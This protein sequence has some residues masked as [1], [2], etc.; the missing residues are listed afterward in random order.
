VVAAIGFVGF[1]V[2]Q[3]GHLEDIRT[4]INA[5]SQSQDGQIHESEKSNA[6][7]PL[8][9]E[10]VYGT[11]VGYDTKANIP[12][13]PDGQGMGIKF[14]ATT[15]SA[16]KSVRFVQR[17][18]PGYSRG[19]GGT[20]T[21]TV[22]AEDS[23]GYPSG[24]SLGSGSITP[25][26]PAEN[27]EK[28]DPVN[29]DNPASLK[30][31][32]NY[33]LEFTNPDPANNISVNNVLTYNATKPRQPMFSDADFGVKISKTGT[34]GAGLAPGYTPVVDLAYANGIHDGQSYYEAMIA[35]YATISG[36]DKAMA[37]EHFTVSGGDRIVT[38]SSVRVRRSGGTSPLTM[39]LE[40]GSGEA[41]EA[42]SVPAESVPVSVPGGDDGGAVWATANFDS[43]HVLTDGVTYNVRVST[44][45]DTTYTT[46]PVRSGDD[47]GLGSYNF[48][49]GT[50]QTTSNGSKWTE[51]YTDGPLR[52]ADMQF[53]LNLAGKPK[54]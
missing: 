29:L 42:V 31:G 35:N 4:I 20:T 40:T 49:G 48:K 14:K 38:S 37:R 2:A 28:Y 36:K 5:G 3:Q 39:T 27:W 33:Y 17:G 53:Y 16:L 34:W 18:G 45:A 7:T 10:G 13:G 15:S 8:A 12:V 32:K 41:I 44:A 46:H 6:T 23:A 22:R 50:G 9:A 11:G 26:N 51:M 47:K 30:A 24:T 21:L 19:N 52:P 54:N 43:P 25:G 1:E